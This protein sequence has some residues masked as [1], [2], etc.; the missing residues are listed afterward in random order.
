MNWY[1][2]TFEDPQGVRK[3]GCQPASSRSP[4][5]PLRQ[6][7]VEEKNVLRLPRVFRNP[8]RVASAAA[9]LAVITAAVTGYSGRGAPDASGAAPAAAA[10]PVTS[11]SPMPGTSPSAGAPA[12]GVL[13]GG[14]AQPS[15]LTHLG[16]SPAIV[17]TYDTIDTASAFP[18]TQE[19]GALRSGA[20]LLASLGTGSNQDWASIAAGTSDTTVLTYL[21]AL[22]TAAIAHH[23][24]SLYVSFNHEPNAKIDAG[25]GSPAQFVA[26][27]RH[28]VR[29]ARPGRPAV[30]EIRT[31]LA[32]GAIPGP[33]PRQPTGSNK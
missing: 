4:H 25:K 21:R 19:T 28:V 3:E 24:N 31:S 27:W 11:A 26:A 6:L 12:A 9:L 30:R 32:D 10:A 8:R 5:M 2:S 7:P 20:T 29:T 33:S 23:L 13:F 1:G 15:G 18:S 17:R 22:N 16:R 14:D